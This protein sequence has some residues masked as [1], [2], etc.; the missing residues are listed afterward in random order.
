ML[1]IGF[2]LVRVRHTESLYILHSSNSLWRI[3]FQLVRVRHTE[4]PG[5]PPNITQRV[6]SFQLV[7]VRHTESQLGHGP[8]RREGLRDVSN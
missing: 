8:L 3:S 7:R 2:Q 4:S 1:L 5:T 6:A